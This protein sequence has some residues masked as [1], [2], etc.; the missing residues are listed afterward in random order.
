M[1]G[2]KSANLDARR[3]TNGTLPESLV[4]QAKALKINIPAAGAAGLAGQVKARRAKQ[5][6]ELL[7]T[8]F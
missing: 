4:A 2:T 1:P 3:A 7:F 6:L 5:W 8:G